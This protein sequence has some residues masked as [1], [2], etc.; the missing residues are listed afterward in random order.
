MRRKTSWMPPSSSYAGTIIRTSPGCPSALSSGER[1]F[2]EYS[3]TA[4]PVTRSPLRRP[5]SRTRPRRFRKSPKR[6]STAMESSAK[7]RSSRPS[8]RVKIPKNWGTTET[9]ATPRAISSERSRSS[10]LPPPRYLYAPYAAKSRAMTT[11][12]MLTCSTTCLPESVLLGHD[13]F[14]RPPQRGGGDLRGVAAVGVLAGYLGDLLQQTFAQGGRLQ[15]QVQEAVVT[16]VQVV[17]VGLVARVLHVVYLRARA[18]GDQRGQVAQTV[19]LGHLVV[20]VD[21]VAL[22]GRVLQGELYAAHGV[23]DMDESAGLAAGAV[24]GERVAHGRLHQEA[25]EDGAVVAVVVEAVYEALV[26]PTLRGLGP[27]HDALVQVGDAR[28]VVLVV[29]GEQELVLGLGHVV[30]AA[31]VGRVEDLLLDHLALFGLD[32]DRQIP[33]GDLHPGRAVAV[34]AHGP[35][36]HHVGVEPALGDRRQQ[37]VGGVEVV[38]YGVA[39]VVAGLHGVGRGPLLGKV[40]DRLGLPLEEQVQKLAVVLGD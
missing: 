34:D 24:D 22:L 25:V 23:L 17:L 3:F 4:R 39:L 26:Q 40:D 14:P 6:S 7:P 28:Q 11:P 35:Q 13:L 1:Y 29:V 8:R 21:P 9:R 33:L 27:P 12:A 2:S 15:A 31:G 20:D 5:A 10:L 18:L 30:D 37:V 32:L 38:V 19:G 36:V 16:D